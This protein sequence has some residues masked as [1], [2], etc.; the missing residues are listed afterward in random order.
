MPTNNFR[1]VDDAIIADLLSMSRSWVRKERFNRRHSL[2]HTFDVDPIMI[3]S[4]PRYRIEEV[5]AFIARLGE[6][7]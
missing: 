6:V 1:L 2:P 7:R 3:G 5:E 4:S